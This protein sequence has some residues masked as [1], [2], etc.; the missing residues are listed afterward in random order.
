M[1]GGLLRLGLLTRRRLVGCFFLVCASR[2]C[3]ARI[4]WRST[5]LNLPTPLVDGIRSAALT[6]H[7]ATARKMAIR[8][9]REN[10]INHRPVDIDCR[11]ASRRPSAGENG[12]SWN[13]PGGC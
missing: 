12:A 13:I 9:L 10:I 5:T 1:A 2:I 8:I 7:A 3:G 4:L 11:G 6:A